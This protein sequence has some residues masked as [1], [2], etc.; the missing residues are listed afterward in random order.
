MF[1]LIIEAINWLRIVASPLIIG[2]L[3]GL[4]IYSKFQSRIGLIVGLLV[5]LL[6]L[7]IG[8]FWA[9]HVL[10]KQGTTQ[11]MS[12]VNATPELDNKEEENKII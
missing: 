2:I 10:K 7:I 6:G 1:K 12:R 11:F 5:A 9:T 8:I 3:L 4:T